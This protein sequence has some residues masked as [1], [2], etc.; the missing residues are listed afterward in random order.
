MLSLHQIFFRSFVTVFLIT[1]AISSFVS[2][3]AIKKIQTDNISKKL[4]NNILL[5]ENSITN[6]DD[7]DTKIKNIQ[8]L[9]NIRITIISNDGTVLAESSTSKDTM[10]NHLSR[11]EILQ[12][13]TNTFGSS[14]RFSHTI[15]TDFLYVAKKSIVQNKTIYIGMSYSL[16]KVFEEFSKLW[17]YLLIIFFVSIIFA[18]YLAYRLNTKIQKDV[19]DIKTYLENIV[20]KNYNIKLETTFCKEFVIIS[21]LI[22]K[23]S[24]K[25]EKKAKQKRKQTAKLKLLN[26]QKD[27]IIS[28]ISHEFKNPIAVIVGY[29]ETLLNDKNINE[30]IRDRFLEK[31]SHNAN[32]MSNMINRLRLIIN[33]DNKDFKI[34]FSNVNVYNITNE[35]I[36][37]LQESYKD[38]EIILQGNANTSIKADPILI[39]IAITN[40]I[41]NGLKYS[42]DV[43]E[44]YI[45]NDFIAIKDYGCGI[46]EDDLSKIT[47]KFYRVDK[48]IWNNSLGIGL[49]IVSKIINL[50]N[51]RLSIASKIN[52]GSIFSIYFDNTENK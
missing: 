1:I 16:D 13:N 8:S 52:E 28:S 32:K 49:S 38:R 51:F 39:D 42:E 34:N 11:D 31:I 18:L 6:L 12:S 29:C 19:N 2:Y 5:F 23:L 22:K 37:L 40:L 17:F 25:L 7:I 9:T 44:I 30:K 3:H 45:Q 35:T 14:I 46:D 15:N 48:N 27:D 24:N 47:E 50:H 26:K 36:K 33:L 10:D 21:Y 4:Q 41:E 20:S 43:I